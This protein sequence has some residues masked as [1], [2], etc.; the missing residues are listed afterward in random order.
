MDFEFNDVQR[1]TVEMMRRFA[2]NEL[3]PVAHEL[4]LA[5]R[6]DE[7][8][9]DKA[10][11][12]GLP[13]DAVPA[14]H[15]GYLE[16]TFS[17]LD[18]VLRNEVLGWGCAGLTHQ[19]ESIV[20]IALALAKASEDGQKRW[21]AEITDE[22]SYPRGALLGADDP[23]E[24]DA[25]GDGFRISGEQPAVLLAPSARLFLLSARGPAGL[26]VAIVPGGAD[27]VIITPVDNMAW[28]A[29]DC[30][31]VRLDDVTVG[32]DAVLARGDDAV[33]LWNEVLSGA[34]LTAAARSVGIADAAL[35]FAREYAGE[36][37]QFGRPILKFQAVAE[38]L[39]GS[40]RA[41]EASR[42]QVRELAWRLDRGE[43][44]T[45]EVRRAKSQAAAMCIRATIDA[46]QVLGGYGFVSDYPV[47][48]YYRDARVVQSL[49]GHDML[50][51]L[52]KTQAA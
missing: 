8:L 10:R 15:G 39:E 7:G 34:R 47:E 42:H 32:S 48:K 18:R 24:A 23:F 50:Q 19:F 49:Y 26:I 1:Q 2:D 33:R 41:V 30:G 29:C 28:R 46:V 16:G 36:R 27:N 5:R 45:D 31:D 40:R 38:M 9:F 35:A 51:L 17:R 20:P 12:L 11:E 44:V 6:M 43:N 3:R 22:S 14:A 21:F 25:E 52:L 37:V 13:L 4:D